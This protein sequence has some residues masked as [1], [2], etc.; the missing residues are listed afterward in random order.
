MHLFHDS[1]QSQ[2]RSPF[3]AAATGS[4]ITLALDVYDL[5]EGQVYLRLWQDREILIP[6]EQISQHRYAV[7]VTVPEE[8]CLLWYYFAVSTPQGTVCYGLPAGSQKGVGEIMDQPE[9]WQITVYTPAELPGWYRDS[10]VYQIFPDR[11]ARGSDWEE[12]QKNA[13]HPPHWKG[14]HRMVMQDWNDTP[15]YCKDPQGRVVRWPFFGGNFSGIQEKLP[16]LQAMGIGTIYLNPIFL[17]S[18]NHKYDTADYLTID[19]GFGDEESFSRLCRAAE[20]RG[21]RIILDGVFSHTGD[22]SIYFNRYGNFPEPGAFSRSGSPYDSWYRF[23]GDPPAGYA[24]WWGVD[25]LPNVEENNPDFQELI[26]GENGVIRKWL[27]LGASG[28][29]LDVADELPDSFIAKIRA[30]AKAEKPDALILGEVWEDA[31]CK[32]SYGQLREYFFGNE[33]D[34]TMHYPFR[35]GSI[36]FILGKCSAEAFADAMDTIREHYPPAALAGA[37]NLI[38]THDT[39]RILTLLGEAP[40]GLSEAEREVYRLSPHQH[41]L[42]LGRLRLLDVLLFTFPGVPCVYYGDEAGV[43]GYADP[44][45]RSPFPWG[46]EDGEL[47]FFVRKLSHL[48]EDYPVLK[49]GETSYGFYGREVFSLTRKDLHQEITV[50]ANRSQD[51]QTVPLPEPERS[52]LDLL[53]GQVMSGNTLTLRGLGAVMLFREGEQ[54]AFSPLPAAAR[55]PMGEGVLC[56]LFSL[57]SDSRWG[58]LGKPAEDFLSAIHRAGYRS[59]MLLPLCPAGTGNSPY[60]SHG[61]FASDARFLDPDTPVSMEG[62]EDFCRENSFWLEDYAMFTL[63]QKEFEGR[64]WQEWPWRERD[65]R[66]LP[67]IRR[68]YAGELQEIYTEQ[69][70]FQV[71][72]TS[73]REKARAL[74]ISLIGDLP[75]Y[76]AVNSADTWAH[77]ELFQLD[78]KG[79]PTMRS[80]CPPDYFNPGGQDWGNPLYNWD[81]MKKDGYLWWKQRLSLA[82]SRFDYVRLDHFRAFASY[83]AIPAGVSARDGL[84]MKGPGIDF[85]R[86]MEKAFGTL[87]IIAEDLGSLDSE[88]YTLLSHTGLSGMNVWQFSA[89]EML[90]MSPV[91]AA[92]RVFFSGTHDN[93]TLR[94]FLSDQGDP[95]S[96]A[97]ILDIMRRLPASAV[98]FPVQDI[99]DLDD[100]ARINVPG[101]PQGNWNW[102]MT[103]EMVNALGESHGNS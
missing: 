70:R 85:F 89:E 57:P 44:F 26:C 69:Y 74:G 98:I 92:H 88:V 97:E 24:C 55:T 21:I 84:W 59:W 1:R 27:R 6:M 61:I 67:A 103:E 10:V 72:W 37:M 36:D 12:C 46:H 93:Q 28:W 49:Q 102:R 17:A 100:A 56:P 76:S 31:S 16:Y 25:A 91:Q 23:H 99:L 75:I 80:G 65:R 41:W 42:A 73:L 7:S 87:P 82:F 45:N 78:E 63:L 81:V 30:A 71:Q 19:P 20:D 101:V 62:F 11:F 22:D 9:S 77:R 60:S 14:T 29:R 68:K 5:P 43:Q 15:F 3:G 39:P 32:I 48:R 79:Y 53:S 50:Y 35:T 40:E 52:Y 8:P 86:V 33:L 54:T 51:P 18:S 4:Q 13:A 58:T 83:Y 47:Q 64:P 90:D 96:T 2:Y 38:G 95:R 34:C 66:N 94:S